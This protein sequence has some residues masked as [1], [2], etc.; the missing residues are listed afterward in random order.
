MQTTWPVGPVPANTLPSGPTTRHSTWQF[1]P[2]QTAVALPSGATF[3]TFPS[4]PVA[5]YRFPSP[6]SAASQTWS[7]SSAASG[8]STRASRSV[9][10]LLM[11][12]SFHCAFS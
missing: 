5:A 1:S 9:P 10:S 6:S 2:D 12:A 11:T 4:P 3:Q 8:R 7:A